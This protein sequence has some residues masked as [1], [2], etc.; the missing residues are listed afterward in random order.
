MNKQIK[1][2][3]D[4]VQ[5]HLAETER[6]GG[7]KDEIKK[8]KRIKT[9][10]KFLAHKDTPEFLFWY[11][12]HFNKG[13]IE[14]FEKIIATSAELSYYYCLDVAKRR[15]P[16]MEP[17]IST[18]ADCLYNYCKNVAKCRIPEFEA[19][20]AARAKW[21]CIDR[22]C[23]DVAKGRVLEFEPIIATN[24]EWVYIYCVLI[25]KCRIPEFEPIIATRAE[26]VYDYCMYVAKRKI[27]AMEETIKKS[28]W[29][30]ALYSKIRKRGQ[31]KMKIKTKA[32][33]VIV[34]FNGSARCKDSEDTQATAIHPISKDCE[35]YLAY[36]LKK[37]GIPS[38]NG[39]ALIK[40]LASTVIEKLEG[41]GYTSDTFFIDTMRDKI[42]N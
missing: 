17:I 13:R 9:L 36:Y 15:I 11:A 34:C 24:A 22:Y 33:F 41:Q 30:W 19:I 16:E 7:C 40:K 37:N 1:L 39:V 42:N 23:K 18:D 8:L 12:E 38:A 27:P 10:D 26:W 5:A 3:W 35:R 4:T 20:I 29:Y 25:V 14:A 31:K 28:D 2:D 6:C 32:D 21:S